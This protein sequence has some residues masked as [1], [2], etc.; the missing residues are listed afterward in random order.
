MQ[1]ATVGEVW[2]LMFGCVCVQAAHKEV[3]QVCSTR[4]VPPVTTQLVGG[5]VMEWSRDRDRYLNV[6]EGVLHGAGGAAWHLV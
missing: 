3:A 4:R 1:P 5:G 6:S 2:H